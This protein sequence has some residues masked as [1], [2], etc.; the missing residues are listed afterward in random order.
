[1]RHTLLPLP[2][3]LLPATLLAGPASVNVD[4]LPATEPAYGLDE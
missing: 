4:C 2:A 1:M 3:L